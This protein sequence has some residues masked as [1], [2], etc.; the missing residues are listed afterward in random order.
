M[1]SPAIGSWQGKIECARIIKRK[2][3]RRPDWNLAN[4]ASWGAVSCNRYVNVLSFGFTQEEG[5]TSMGFGETILDWPPP[6]SSAREVG[7]FR[8]VYSRRARGRNYRLVLRRSQFPFLGGDGSF[9]AHFEGHDLPKV[10]SDKYLIFRRSSLS[11]GLVFV[12]FLLFSCRRFVL[13]GDKVPSHLVGCGLRNA[14]K[15]SLVA[16]RGAGKGGAC[17][18]LKRDVHRRSL[19]THGA[20]VGKFLGR[21]REKS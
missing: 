16:R 6:C 21:R 17:R 19:L 15:V 13:V 14:S 9:L 5:H 10:E 11:R 1:D 3:L 4:R 2:G 7:G 18:A 12:E 8:K 20:S